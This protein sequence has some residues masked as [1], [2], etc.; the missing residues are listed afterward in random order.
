MGICGGVHNIWN[1]NDNRK[2]NRKEAFMTQDQANLKLELSR[3][4]IENNLNPPLIIDAQWSQEMADLLKTER[5]IQIKVDNRYRDGNFRI[6][7]GVLRGNSKTV[8]PK[9]AI[10]M[11]DVHGDK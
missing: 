10:F 6:V 3:L 9:P 8:S 1:S 4:G 5:T 2:R 7:N 11:S